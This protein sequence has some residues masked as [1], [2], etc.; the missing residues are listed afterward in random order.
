MRVKANAWGSKPQTVEDAIN[1]MIDESARGTSGV[2]ED[3]DYRV[4][5]MQSMLARFMA[6]KITTVEELNNLAGYDRWEEES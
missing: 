3:L 2:L 1:E 6:S 4:R 5:E